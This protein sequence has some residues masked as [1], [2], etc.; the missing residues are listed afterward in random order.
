V[1]TKTVLI[2]VHPVDKQHKNK[3]KGGT[4]GD[5]YESEA[6]LSPTDREFGDISNGEPRKQDT[7]C[8]K[9]GGPIEEYITSNYISTSDSP[10]HTRVNEWCN[11]VQDVDNRRRRT[12]GC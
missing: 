7:L 5:R 3:R 10:W 6:L 11:A 12:S 9:T 4:G 8:I 1:V 2:T